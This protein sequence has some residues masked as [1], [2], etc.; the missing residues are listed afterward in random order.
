MLFLT[1]R[2]QESVLVGPETDSR[3][4]VR[5]TILSIRRHRV[6]LGLEM[7]TGVKVQRWE[8]WERL[9]D[10]TVVRTDGSD[11]RTTP[12]TGTVSRPY[13]CVRRK[14]ISE[15]MALLTDVTTDD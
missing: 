5:V 11:L 4:C 9:Q 14:R 15:A 6:K 1:C 12:E 8:V 13:R 7:A 10:S 3:H 2:I